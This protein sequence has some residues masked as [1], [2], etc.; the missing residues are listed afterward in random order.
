MRDAWKPASF[1]IVAL[2]LP[3]AI[4]LPLLLRGED[5]AFRTY[6]RRVAEKARGNFIHAT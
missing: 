3:F 6:I 4:A 1:V 5:P 2:G